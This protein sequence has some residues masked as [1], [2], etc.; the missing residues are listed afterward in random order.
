MN[1]MKACL[2][3]AGEMGQHHVEALCAVDGVSLVG[4]AEADG[5]RLERV[6]RGRSFKRYTSASLMLRQQRPDFVA[7]AVPTNQHESVAVQCLEAG[8]HVIVEKP[9]A[10][11]I[12]GALR[13]E[14]EARERGLLVSVGHIERFN[15]AVI[16]LVEKLSEGVVGR[17]FQVGARRTGP[18]PPRV[19]DVGAIKD[20]ATHDLDV[21]RFIFGSPFEFVFAQLA[22]HLHSEHEDL[23]TVVGRLEN[24]A[25]ASLDVNW[26]TPTKVR[27]LRVVGEGGMY[28][29]DYIRQDLTLYR[30]GGHAPGFGAISVF[31]SVAEGEVIQYPVHRKEPLRAEIESFVQAIRAGGPPPVSV[32][33]AIEALRLADAILE[34][35]ERNQPVRLGQF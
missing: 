17:I 23:G 29:L 2:I 9:V 35:A 4:V 12:R 13:I 30:N 32:A 6:A 16:G 5:G 19:R 28:V 26:L 1:D 14:G 15:P 10:A 21:I 25:I 22:R 8:A 33:E 31:A 27:E 34:S 18:F 20:L 11:D 24:G 7:V 3:G